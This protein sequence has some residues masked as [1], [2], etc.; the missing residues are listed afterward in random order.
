MKSNTQIEKSTLEFLKQLA[1]NNNRDWFAA[2]KH[3]YLGAKA[4]VE[5]FMDQVILK[6]N[7]HDVLE[8]P[9]GKKSL[10][11]IYNDVR[12]SKDKA[13]YKARFAA[14]LRRLK[15]QPI[16]EAPGQIHK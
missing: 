6:M 9:N 12:F 15:P 16:R 13:P 4:N 14:Y 8:T 1:L 7:K 2:H 11:W 3:Q 5:A 10:Y